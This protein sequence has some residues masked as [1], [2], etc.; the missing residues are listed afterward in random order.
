MSEV[1]AKSPKTLNKALAEALP[2][3][4]SP[5]PW[6]Q[7]PI[8]SIRGRL[9]V[10]ALLAI[11]PLM[12]ERM[13]GLERAR[14]ERAELARAQVVDLARS[15]VAAQ[16]EVINST[17]ALLQVAARVFAKMPLDAPDCNQTL[18]DLTGSVPW[19][20]GIAVANVE[21]RFT[22]GSDPAVRGLNVSDRPYFV[23]A[24]RSRDFALSDYLIKRVGG[25]PGVMATYPIV[26]DGGAVAGVIVA[27]IDLQWIG[28]LAA[29]A[30]QNSGTSVFMIDGN[31]TLLVGSP[32]Q[33]PYLGKRFAEHELTQQML[34]RDE[35]TLTTV[36]FDG[37]HRILAYVRVPSTQAHLAVG[38]DESVVHSG[39][40][41]EISIAYVQL[42][43]FGLL[44]LLAAWFGGERLILRP[45]RSLVRTAT[46][47]G[48]GDLRARAANESWMAEFEPLAA[49]LDDMAA[50]LAA[51]EEELQIANQHLEELA[52]LDGLTGLANRRG[53]DRELERTWRQADERRQPL[54]LMMIDIDHFK[55]F[56]DRYGHVRGDACLRAVGETLS[57][58]TLDE[59]V[60]V[61]RYGGE[62]FALLLP[63]LGIERTT[64]IA[65][66]ARTAIEDLL[67]THA[68]ATC[69][70][71]TI[72]I[73]VESV[74]PEP[75]QSAA[76]LVEAADL[77]LYDAKR[78]GRN[79]V[80]A[81]SALALRAAS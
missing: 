38:L 76:D 26:K 51:R 18:A 15:G 20:R 3:A 48:R 28:E 6:R 67:I 81:Y 29:N 7:R 46:Q 55:L 2:A 22:C 44:V 57:M 65:E 10:V 47:F 62:E 63:G 8:L 16:R 25:A 72:S 68:D 74:V 43:M 71:V 54:A 40:D 36:G 5:K 73:G 66:E 17:R 69:G 58:V 77:A 37:I 61:A 80:V 50:K 59:A 9:I 64:E 31:G 19:I 30:A 45:I 49:A 52:S 79:A 12:V 23:N 27:S 21:G 14:T 75:G 70:I 11:A 34:A 39:I 33:R 53:F 41:R 42:G 78:R 1:Q 13:R 56:N 24:L 4:Q 32:D 60:I 35:G